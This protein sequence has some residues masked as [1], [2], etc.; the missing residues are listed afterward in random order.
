VQVP[1]RGA[2][3]LGYTS[4]RVGAVAL[5]SNEG[6]PESRSG[7]RLRGIQREG[8]VFHVTNGVPATPKGGR[9]VVWILDDSPMEAAMARRALT[10]S[11]DVVIFSDGS[12]LLEQLAAGNGPS[13]L[14]LDGQLHGM[15]GI[16]VCRFLRSTKNEM[17]LP[18]LMLSVHGHRTTLVDGLEAGAND[19]LTKPYDALELVA[20]VAT[21][22]RLHA[23]YQET[24]QAE[25]QRSDL[26]ACERDARADAEAA[27]I[28]K[29]DFVAMVSHE[30]RTPL[31][32]ILGWTRIVRAGK[33][34]T[35]QQERA[36]ATVERNATAQAQ[37]IED[38][39]DMSSILSGKLTIDAQPLDLVTVVRLAVDAT[40]PSAHAKGVTLDVHIPSDRQQTTGD[41]ARL[42]QVIWNLLTNAIK[43]TAKGGRVLL[44]LTQVDGEIELSV[45]DSGRGIE[46]EFLPRVFDRF[47]QADQGSKRRHGG[48]GLGLAIV[49]H[50]VHLHAGS[51]VA[52][53]DG[54][55]KG[56]TFRVRLPQTHDDAGVLLGPPI[57]APESVAEI[58]A[59]RLQGVRVLLFDD[60]PDVLD[61][62]TTILRGAG[63]VTTGASSAAHAL[64]LLAQVRPDVIVSDIG[65]P[66][67]DGYE[68]IADI[69]SLSP[70]EGG[71][72]PAMALTAFA[73]RDDRARAVAAG[74]D[75]YAT[76][77]VDLAEFVAT[78]AGLAGRDPEHPGT[79][80]APAE[81]PAT[82]GAGDS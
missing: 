27:S 28:A 56:A 82:S 80:P 64:D 38:L 25:A 65:M 37:L 44:S 66:L 78:I 69:R 32:A 16:E 20:R 50:I 1:F 12:V 53:S 45:A 46:R 26:L 39:L 60:D 79:K 59:T 42:Q 33:L 54:A 52:E 62:L 10:P 8:T 24:R 23:L 3:E 9:P 74:F 7:L 35:E 22:G 13:V 41:P 4:G 68:L 36:L 58:S 2:L 15:S 72:T 81:G 19:S 76:K 48:L 21:L 6:F 29:D 70:S 47:R 11:S 71:N 51:V 40:R 31:N 43:F 77:P 57:A 63:A 55:G 61:L 67:H 14:V 34:S 17:E 30:L 49:K 18:I 73:S 75:R 5:E